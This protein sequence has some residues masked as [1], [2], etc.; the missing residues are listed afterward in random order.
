MLVRSEIADPDHLLRAGMFADFQIRIG[1]PAQSL[2]LPASGVVR[3]GDGTTAAWTTIDRKTFKRR[4]VKVG[5][6]QN[7]NYLLLEGLKEN[8]LAVVDGAIFLSNKLAG[9]AGD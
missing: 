7:G 9:G 2:A 6:L 8:E 5:Q 3:E 1:N 4:V